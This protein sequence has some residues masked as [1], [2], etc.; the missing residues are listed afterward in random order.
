MKKTI[1]VTFFVI[2]Y[3]QV[4]YSGVYKFLIYTFSR[5]FERFLVK[6]LHFS[7][8]SSIFACEI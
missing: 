6:V 8:K 5:F 1:S 7:K 4:D 3:I 2:H